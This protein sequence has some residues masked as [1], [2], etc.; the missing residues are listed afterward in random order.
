MVN[1]F[2]VPGTLSCLTFLSSQ[3]VLP[4]TKAP[5]QH[6]NMQPTVPLLVRFFF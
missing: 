3:H 2:D 6:I 4:P 5:H 1:A